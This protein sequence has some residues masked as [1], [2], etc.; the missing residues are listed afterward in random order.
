MSTL[1]HLPPRGGLDGPGEVRGALEDQAGIAFHEDLSA[2]GAAVLK[3]GEHIR[4]F[5][6]PLHLVYERNSSNQHS[7]N[8]SR[9]SDHDPSAR[10]RNPDIA[11]GPRHGKSHDAPACPRAA[12]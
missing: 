8:D 1:H 11:R 12:G 4:D 5:R 7:K 2:D 10:Y 3:E 6:I 9:N